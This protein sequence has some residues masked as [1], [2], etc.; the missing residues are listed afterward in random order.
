M[1]S[2]MDPTARSSALHR[3]TDMVRAASQPLTPAEHGMMLAVVSDRFAARQRRRARFLRLSMV[4]L[5]AAAV[6]CG[7]WMFFVHPRTQVKPP[8]QLTYRVEG[9][10]IL[11]G[12]YLRAFGDTGMKLRFAEGTELEFLPGARGRL[13]SVEEH[14][15][16]FSVEQGAASVKVTPRPGAH[17][18]I[19]AGPFLIT[20]KGTAFTV[21]W[22]ATSEQLDLRLTKGLVSVTGGPLSEG[23]IAVHAGQHLAVNLPKKEVLLQEIEREHAASESSAEL[24]PPSAPQEMPAKANSAKVR[25][26][27]LPRLAQAKEARSWRAALV[28]GDVDE[29]LRDVEQMGIRRALAEA[30]SEN[31]S[32][33]ASAARYRRHDDIAR[34][35]LLAQ[36]QRFPKSARATEAAF[37][38]GR[39][40][41]SRQ[42]GEG[43]ALAWYDEY[44]RR[45]PDGE[46]AAEALGRK[47]FAMQ[48]L[49]RTVEARTVAREYLQR[50]PTG[51]YAGAAGAL[52]DYP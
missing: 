42:G 52:C 37:L 15:A 41:E 6:T 29:I 30:S 14:G 50:F 11:K 22:N 12:G 27:D 34:Q 36:R 1:A 17:W 44:L 19:D 28:A 10:E 40:D 43:R 24:P 7:L 47:M 25:P 38:L 32:I 48:K 45:A 31:L 35:A 9:G 46:F 5:G 26:E 49:K 3:V 39:L 13:E 18:L 23:A 33:L 8:D 21:A 51:S 4:G 2:D 16:H 20:V